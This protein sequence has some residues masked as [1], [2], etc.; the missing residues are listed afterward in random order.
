MEYKVNRE[1]RVKILI[2]GTDGKTPTDHPNRSTYAIRDMLAFGGG[3]LNFQLRAIKAGATNDFTGGDFTVTVT[4][5]SG[6]GVTVTK[7]GDDITIHYQSGVSTAGQV[8]DALWNNGKGTQGVI[9]LE[10]NG[11]ANSAVLTAPGDNGGPL[12]SSAGTDGTASIKWAQNG[13]SG[14]SENTTNYGR[15]HLVKAGTQTGLHEVVIPPKAVF[16]PGEATLEVAADATPTV[17][18]AH[19]HVRVVGDGIAPNLSGQVIL[20]NEGNAARRRFYFYI[21]HN[22][23]PVVGAGTAGGGWNG[24]PGY[25][26][27]ITKNNGGLA[28]ITTAPTEVSSTLLPGL[29][30]SELTSTMV[31]T[32]GQI[33]LQPTYT[34]ESGA[35]VE[36]LGAPVIA[37]VV[38]FNQ[39]DSVRM[40]MTALPNAAAAALGGL[41]TRGTGAGQI[42]QT[43]NGR[44][45]VDVQNLVTAARTQVENAVWDAL[46]AN[47][48]VAGSFGELSSNT[49]GTVVSDAGNTAQTFKTSLTT[50]GTNAH[51]DAWLTFLSGANAGQCHKVTAFD[52]G[53]DFITTAKPYTNTPAAT[54]RFVLITK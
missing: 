42:N 10:T 20:L 36:F 21:H 51:E 3:K 13:I 26:A 9:P 34:N 53:T 50:A 29:Y 33:A 48:T 43:T 54:D 17:N 25:G 24:L 38:A 16:Q 28:F 31:D 14:I 2:T 4:G 32:L 41:Y 1:A 40:G 19:R 45:D 18:I 15:I 27:V 35:P 6:S 5:D 7:T 8:W 11:S 52:P 23:A 39:Y 46:P 30:Y 22:G 44:I 12:S 37:N 47:H 49:T